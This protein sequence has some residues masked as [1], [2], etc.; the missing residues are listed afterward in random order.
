[1]KEKTHKFQKKVEFTRSAIDYFGL[2]SWSLISKC[3]NT[4][5]GIA[6][7]IPVPTHRHKSQMKQL[8]KT[9]FSLEKRLSDLEK[10]GVHFQKS[11]SL[12]KEKRKI[13]N[14]TKTLFRQIVEDNKRLN[15]ML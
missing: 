2:V 5:K 13:D 1:M 15:K 3:S 14:G 8:K 9:I 10:H 4:V 12:I 7:E 6:S 11:A